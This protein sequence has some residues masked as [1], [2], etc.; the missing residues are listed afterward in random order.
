MSSVLEHMQILGHQSSCVNQA[1]RSLRVVVPLQPEVTV[2]DMC[3]ETQIRRSKNYQ[4]RTPL[5]LRP[6]SGTLRALYF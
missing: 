2:N 4:E 5:D 6:F 1:L 3:R